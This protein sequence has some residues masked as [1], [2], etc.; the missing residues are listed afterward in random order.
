MYS[1]AGDDARRRDRAEEII[2][3]GVRRERKMY[4]PN[5]GFKMYPD[6]GNTPHDYYG[7][8]TA[9]YLWN[10]ELLRPTASSALLAAI[11]DGL[12]MARD[13]TAAYK[14]DFPPRAATGPLDAYGVIRFGDDAR[15]R[16]KAL[17]LL[18]S[19]AAENTQG[20]PKISRG[21]VAWRV[22]AAYAAAGLFRAGGD[23]AMP[24]ALALANRVVSE[25]G[26]E[27]RLYSTVDSVAA[28]AL[29]MELQA[30]G[31]VGRGSRAVV[32]GRTI[33]IVQAQA[34]D[35]T[36]IAA[37]GGVVAVE[38][39]RIVEEDWERFTSKLPVTITTLAK[40]RPTA[41]A[42]VGDAIDLHVRLDGGYEAGD[43]VWVA[44]PDSLSRVIGGGQVKRF[45]VDLAGKSEITIPLAATAVTIDR[46]GDE[47]PQHFAVCV[48]N[49]FEEERAGNPGP[50]DIT[51]VPPRGGD[52][53]VGRAVS[54]LRRLLT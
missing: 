39:T 40:G 15:A 34:I 27:G 13:A 25:L 48:R 29:M 8:A 1:F 43:L 33:P 42:T 53:I 28:I 32:D 51:I 46:S 17:A 31:I 41:R 3:A 22:D 37:D 10:L 45:S 12:T 11:D 14:I 50:I 24:A 4:L 30:A 54:A 9:R 44:L 35:A 47:A 6:S 49:M 19:Y 26:S 16:D 23:A 7:K 38:V 36:E 18:R 2:I 20:A 21:A 5:R 52:G